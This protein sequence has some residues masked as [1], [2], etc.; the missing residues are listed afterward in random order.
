VG[1]FHPICVQSTLL[2]AQEVNSELRNDSNLSWVLISGAG[3]SYGALTYLE[4]DLAPNKCRWC[5]SNSLDASARNQLR[6]S[7]TSLA[8]NVS[9][10]TG[11]VL[12]PAFAFASHAWLDWWENRIGQFYEEALIIS[13]ATLVAALTGELIQLSVGR[14]RPEAHFN[15]SAPQ[16]ASQNT[17][18]YSGHTTIAFALA[19]SSGT[20]ATLRNRSEAPYIWTGGLILSSLTA[21]L[22]VAADRHYLTDV[23]TGAVVGSLIG[24]SLPYFLH[25]PKVFEEKASS[26]QILLLPNSSGLMAAASWAW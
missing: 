17:S 26:V 6:W 18:F 2:G 1:A 8:N 25:S 4:D 9:H 16:G 13:E 19:A 10:L 23:I 12:S 7:N 15:A 20:L 5:S 21:Y 14:Q 24:F 11:F 3:L 22:R